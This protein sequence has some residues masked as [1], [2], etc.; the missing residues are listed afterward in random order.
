V[1][2]G[3]LRSGVIG[4]G[5]TPQQLITRERLEVSGPFGLRF[6]SFDRSHD[7]VVVVMEV[8]KCRVDLCWPQIRMLPQ[9]FFR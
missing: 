4:H 6:P 1:T 5:S 9:N 3:G 2:W 7:G 8:G